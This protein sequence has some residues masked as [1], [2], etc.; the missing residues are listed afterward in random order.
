VKPESSIALSSSVRHTNAFAV[1]GRLV[2]PPAT[3]LAVVFGFWRLGA[4]LSWTGAFPIA[5]GILSRYQVWFAIA[6][7]LH[8]IHI[9][10]RP[11][12][13]NSENMVAV[14]RPSDPLWSNDQIRLLAARHR[15]R[16]SSCQ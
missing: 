3:L 13:S 4:D 15:H 7:A 10:P 8:K 5:N 9:D 12:D 14:A 11:P 16:T 1:A 6:I 2:S